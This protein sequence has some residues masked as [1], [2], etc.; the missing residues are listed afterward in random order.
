MNG[1]YGVVYIHV[2][3]LKVSC[4]CGRYQC[5]NEKLIGKF[6]YFDI[7]ICILCVIRVA[8]LKIIVLQ[9]VR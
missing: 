8:V 2:S 6:V 9:N 5:E 1:S 3:K 7:F 4:N